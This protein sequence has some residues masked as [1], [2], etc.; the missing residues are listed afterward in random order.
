MAEAVRRLVCT[1]VQIVAKSRLY[2]SAPV[3]PA[4]QPFFLNAAV[5]I[6]TTL[7]PKRLL[8]HT[9][10]IEAAM[11]RTKTVRWGPRLID[12]DIA[13]YGELQIDE[14]DLIIPHRELSNRRF[15]LAPLA[16]LAPSLVVPKLDRSVAELLAALT[17]DPNDL[18]AIAP[19]W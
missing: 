1:E 18:T 13:L 14:P 8:A 2:R 9:Q 15:V 19:A 7:T 12:L 6:R 10:G 17:D 11:G 4:D 5:E 16:D 3:G